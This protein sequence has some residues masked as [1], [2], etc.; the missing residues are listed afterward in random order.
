MSN[1]NGDTYTCCAGLNVLEPTGRHIGEVSQ[2]LDKLTE[3]EVENG[4]SN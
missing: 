4:I 3:S 2:L 1:D